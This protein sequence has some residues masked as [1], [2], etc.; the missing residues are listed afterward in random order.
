MFKIRNHVNPKILR[1]IYFAIFESHLTCSSIVWA[2]N[3]GSVK[4][5]IILQKKALRIIN[6]K[7]RNYHTKELFKE[8]IILKLIVKVHL[9]N[10]LFVNKCINNLL[11]TIFNDC[12]TLVSAQH[13]YQTSSSTNK[14]LF[15]PP[16]KTISHGK[17]SVV[18]SSIQSWNNAQQKL[19]SL[20]TLLSTKIKK[21]IT[22]EVLKNY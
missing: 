16:F 20:K 15:K 4:R 9:E 12:F 21:L 8:N 6:F 14:K 7:P 3:P 17:N 22:D 1:S 13:S 5:L 11:P 18:A 10:I 19:G 2:Q